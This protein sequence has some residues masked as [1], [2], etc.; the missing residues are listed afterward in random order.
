MAMASI[1]FHNYV[2]LLEG[3]QWKMAIYFSNILQQDSKI[4]QKHP[5]TIGDIMDLWDIHGSFME[6][7]VSGIQPWMI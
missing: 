5:K 4:H 1:D 7:V 3:H 2:S 6:T